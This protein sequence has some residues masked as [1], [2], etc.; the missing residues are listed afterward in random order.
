MRAALSTVLF[1]AVIL[2]GCGSEKKDAKSTDT[3][4]IDAL[5]TLP[6]PD[7]TGTYR[8]ARL[9]FYA[10]PSPIELTSMIK[11]SGGIFRREMLH[12]PNKANNYQS[13]QKKALILGVYGADLSYSA[14]FNNQSDAIKYL[15]A[16]KRVGESI[17]IQEAFRGGLIERA[18]RNLDNRDSMLN[19]M[20]EMYWETNSQLKEENRN[21]IALLVVAGGWAEGL[22]LGARL[23]EEDYVD[24]RLKLRM[25]EQKYAASELATLFDQFKEDPLVAETHVIF[26]PVLK[27]YE[28][29][30]VK[31]S[32][33]SVSEEDGKVSIKGLHAIELTESDM[34][35]VAQ[36]AIEMRNQIVEI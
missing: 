20:T 13:I 31:S 29:V 17:G 15:A 21:P 35:K 18:N 14:V 2:Y 5:D 26:E 36:L 8:K 9:I 10:M 6:P 34:A 25:A 3:S 19:I 7:T 24:P 11:N 27:F 22:Y 28:A 4:A 12:D 33:F 1:L 30:D 23:L 16:S 32:D